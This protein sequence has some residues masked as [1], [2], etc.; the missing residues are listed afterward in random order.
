MSGDRINLRGLIALPSFC[1]HAAQNMNVGNADMTCM[2]KHG[3][4]SSTFWPKLKIVVTDRLCK[5]LNKG[6]SS[7]LTVSLRSSVT[8]YF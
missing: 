7:C 6:A 3:H 2:V 1:F 8:N 5:S 4:D